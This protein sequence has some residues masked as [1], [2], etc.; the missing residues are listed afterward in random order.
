M[1]GPAAEI[2]GELRVE[3]LKLQFTTR[4]SIR[5]KNPK[6]NPE[7]KKRSKTTIAYHMRTY[8]NVCIRPPNWMYVNIANYGFHQ[9]GETKKERYINVF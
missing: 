9:K 1:V 3:V 8:A 5:K 6:K 7:R 4:I 2:G